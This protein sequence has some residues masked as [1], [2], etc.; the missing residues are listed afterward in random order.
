MK[1][2]AQKKRLYPVWFLA[3]CAAF[4]GGAA[5][6]FRTFVDWKH[7][8]LVILSSVLLTAAF[9][10]GF[11]LAFDAGGKEHTDKTKLLT[12][13]IGTAVSE[14]VLWT[15]LTLVNVG[16]QYNRRAIY[17]AY[18]ILMPLF[19]FFALAVL[20]RI[21]KLGI[22][23]VN[24]LLALLCVAGMAAAAVAPIM[25]DPNEFLIK[26]LSPGLPEFKTIPAE[27]MAVTDEEKQSCAKWF[28]EHILLDEEKPVPA[29]SLEIDGVDLKDTVSFFDIRR[30]DPVYRGEGET[31]V[32]TLTKAGLEIRAVG[33]IYE[34]KATCEWTVYVKNTGGA[35]SAVI[36]DVLAL[37]GEFSVRSPALYYSTG[38]QSR[39]DDF[40][41]KK[42]FL[43]PTVPLRF[44]PVGGRSSDGYL[45]FFNVSG[46]G[47][48]VIAAIGWTGEWKN[49]VIKTDDGVSLA[50]GQKDFSAALLPGEEIRT[51]RVSLTFY[52]SSYPVKGFNLFR[53]FILDCVEPSN[54]TDLTSFV[55]A[56]E[57][58]TLTAGELIEKANAI[59]KDKL[60]YFNNFWMDAGWYDYQENW[61]DG[62]GTWSANRQKFP[63]TLREVG[64]TAAAMG[65]KYLLWFEPE[66][67]RENTFLYEEGSKH[68]GWLIELEG[69]KDRMWNLANDEAA[70]FLS[71][72]ITA[73][74]KENGVTVYR[75][76]FNF[77]PLAYWRKADA[78][79][80]GGRTGIAENRYVTNLYRYLDTLLRDNPGLL[81]DNCSSGGRRLDL[82]MT[83]RSVPLWRSDYNCDASRPDILEATQ[84][85]TYGLSFW[86]PRYGTGY[87][88]QDVYA[89]RSS[90]MPCCSTGD[91]VS[92]FIG[93]YEDL[94]DDM[95]EDYYPM[96]KGGAKKNAAVAMQY[97][98]AENGHA[99]LY[100]REKLKDETVTVCFSGLYSDRLYTVTNRDDPTDVREMSGSQLMKTGMVV[101]VIETRTAPVYD[102]RLSRP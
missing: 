26:C 97:G 23:F 82:E 28:R 12:F 42:A 93:A 83:A 88:T 67:V 6:F 32:V 9:S 48:G 72:Y 13:L 5:A 71:G 55:L 79:L 53:D 66:R 27:S 99:V 101:P 7:I 38:S 50:V 2:L 20:H 73:S 35:E 61:A 34:E 24:K 21:P 70:D 65:K 47:S 59:P 102:Y 17:T 80:Y 8:P 56:D 77:A 68:E 15:V 30:S 22:R 62:V 78:E 84:A 69:E 51:P 54:M 3:A 95:L 36:S 91:G 81:I 18:F 40:T 58:S 11:L 60:A 14:A 100:L 33:T 76:D 25:R 86:L 96:T 90:V 94:R 63:N 41:M 57:F 43:V 29:F 75:Q 98:S 87:Y 46:R 1:N 39:A 37:D 85:M 64:D 45:P 44:S 10:F 49:D 92:D 4:F 19:L 16:G 52:Q 31:T 74:L 89:A